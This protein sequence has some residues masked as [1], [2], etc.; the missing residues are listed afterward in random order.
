MIRVSK[1]QLYL[2]PTGYT[3]L[4]SFD[5]VYEV[6]FLDEASF[7]HLHI[8]YRPQA[9]YDAKL[10][11]C[12]E[13]RVREY[14]KLNQDEMRFDDQ[15]NGTNIWYTTIEAI[16]LQYPKPT[17]LLPSEMDVLPQSGII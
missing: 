4:D 15:K 1:E 8:E 11:V 7:S 13:N 17:P 12:I 10:K 2:L 16:K 6:T 3:V 9:L 5:S 14:G